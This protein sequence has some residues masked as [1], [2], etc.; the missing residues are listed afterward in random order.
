MSL[1]NEYG[2]F[3]DP[4]LEVLP[5][6]GGSLDGKTFAVKD[7][8]AVR[9]HTSSAGNPD[10]L[11]SHLPAKDHA[12]AVRRLLL[13]GA[14]LKG[15]AHTDELMYSLGGEN[16]H[17]GTPVNPWGK[18]R[19]PGGS[20]SG[21]AVAVSSGSVDF[22]LGTDTGGSV[23]VPA[24][25]CGVY[26][27]RPSRG[28]VRMSGVIPLAPSFDTV[29]WMTRSPE[30]LLAVGEVLLKRGAADGGIRKLYI[31]KD[32]WS[33]A[34]PE[35]AESWSKA[36]RR[37]QEGAVRSEEIEVA[38]E[39]L[40]AWMDAFRELQGSEIWETHGDW[41]RRESPSFAP[42]IAARF[43][44]AERFAEQDHS[45]AEAL[46]LA[47]TRRLEDLLGED[48]A[49]IVPTVPGTAPPA[50]GTPA[51]LER[52][53]SG[54]MSLCCIAGLAGLPQITLP[55]DGP[56]GL[57]LGLSVIGAGNR[58]LRLLDWVNRIGELAQ[59]CRKHHKREVSRNDG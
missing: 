48:G 30:L 9:G 38:K 29:G 22:A 55:V 50:G 8:F 51:E 3:I 5:L 21:S 40:K 37:L 23:R 19:I 35:C 6:A 15:A 18:G 31:A 34:A 58:D 32:A 24:S 46:L 53:R 27:I 10:W 14:A 49:L 1:N 41:I 57:P 13:A 17:F 2:A 25:Y 39:G 28:A 20:S 7:V 26:G 47:V 11:R 45:E 44:L 36:L 33:L 43:A 42:D 56:G 12:D 54:A 16:I 52:N 4:A 59:V